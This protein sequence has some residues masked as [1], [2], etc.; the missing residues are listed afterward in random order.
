VRRVS[1]T[2]SARIELVEARYEFYDRLHD[3]VE[4]KMTALQ[5]VR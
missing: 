2:A 4:R 5:I 1:G 3:A